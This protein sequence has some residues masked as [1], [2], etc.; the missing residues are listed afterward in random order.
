MRGSILTSRRCWECAA[1]PSIK[2]ARPAV[3]FA[4]TSLLV[5]RGHHPVNPLARRGRTHDLGSPNCVRFT[6]MGIRKS[7][8]SL[9]LLGAAGMYAADT[10]LDLSIA[11]NRM[12]TL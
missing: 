12:G 11:H 7:V 8:F 3:I 9:L 1:A 4:T 6:A 10:G 2:R 5:T